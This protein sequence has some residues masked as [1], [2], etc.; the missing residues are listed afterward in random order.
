MVMY[1]LPALPYDYAALEP[2]I[3]EEIMHLHH[4]KHHQGYVDK[5]NAAL[6]QRPEASLSL[7][8]LLRQAKSLPEDIRTAVINNGG[9]H[10]NHSLFWQI[11]SPNGGGEPNGRLLA[12]IVQ[13]YGSFQQFVDAFSNKALGVF[14]S[15]WAWLMPN[16]D[17]VTTQNQINPIM[18]GEPSPILGLD[19]WE[20]AYYL[21]YKNV[22]ADYVK[23]WWNVVNWPEVE[24]RYV[25]EV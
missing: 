12:D 16:M 4:Q 11:M 19:V 22:R 21:D 10:Y 14:G 24:K 9:G 6:S 20:H 15:G 17:I 23:A 3:S 18:D 2:A 5:L 1:T 13:K 25:S 7:E 8:Q